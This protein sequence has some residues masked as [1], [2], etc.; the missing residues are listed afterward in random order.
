MCYQSQDLGFKRDDVIRTVLARDRS[1]LTTSYYLILFRYGRKKLQ[2][3]PQ[4][5]A[6]HQDSL[7]EYA[8]TVDDAEVHRSSAAGSKYAVASG[9]QSGATGFTPRSSTAPRARPVSAPFGYAR[10]GAG[11][12]AANYIAANR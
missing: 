9:A 11:N 6:V 2:L 10:G 1:C 12:T 3:S 7:R 4:A 8:E 5:I